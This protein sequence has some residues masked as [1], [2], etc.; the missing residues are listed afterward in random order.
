M[1]KLFIR[2]LRVSAFIGILPAELESRQDIL[3]DVEIATD[4]KEIAKTDNIEQAID[5]ADVRDLIHHFGEERRYN[6][7]ETLADKLADCLVEKYKTSWVRVAITKPVV[8]LDAQGA[9]VV[10]ERGG[11]AS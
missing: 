8:F 6:L 11:R 2:Q 4:A 7:V 9:G 10:V 1:D 3:V 5:Y